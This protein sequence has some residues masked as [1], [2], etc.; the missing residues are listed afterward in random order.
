MTPYILASH[1]YGALDTWH[2]HL[3]DEI[4]LFYVIVINLKCEESDIQSVTGNIY[5]CHNW[6]T[7]IYFCNHKEHE[8]L[9]TDHILP[10]K[11]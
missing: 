4:A 3:K 8:I 2:V 11:A 5:V 7:W 10:M 1:G 9:N 6:D